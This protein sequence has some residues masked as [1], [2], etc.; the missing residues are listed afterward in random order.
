MACFNQRTYAMP[1]SSPSLP[2]IVKLLKSIHG[3]D[4]VSLKTDETQTQLHVQSVADA[5]FVRMMPRVVRLSETEAKAVNGELVEKLSQRISLHGDDGCA[6]MEQPF[7]T[8]FKAEE[9]GPAV[10][11]LPSVTHVLDMGNGT[12]VFAV[13]G[14]GRDL[15]IA[16]PKAVVDYT[17]SVPAFCFKSGF[18]PFFSDVPQRL[19]ELFAAWVKRGRTGLVLDSSPAPRV[20]AD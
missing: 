15:L 3:D 13:D 1:N 9:V 14:S 7:P 10:R 18:S 16:G 12:F 17:S 20:D 5:D 8:S 2:G 6:W 19:H 11:S 4:G